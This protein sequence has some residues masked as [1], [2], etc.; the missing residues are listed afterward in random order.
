MVVH[1]ALR[2]VYQMMNVLLPHLVEPNSLCHASI[3]R[4]F[5]FFFSVLALDFI[6]F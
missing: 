4:Y 3:L 6:V 1:H 2:S 5:D